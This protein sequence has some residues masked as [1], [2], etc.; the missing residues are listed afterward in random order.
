MGRVCYGGRWWN[1]WREDLGFPGNMS[2]SSL[3][4]TGTRVRSW[5]P[6]LKERT[7]IYPW[8]SPIPADLAPVCDILKKAVGECPADHWTGRSRYKSGQ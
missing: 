5:S 1:I 3:S 7:R 6:N 4:T 8:S 2:T